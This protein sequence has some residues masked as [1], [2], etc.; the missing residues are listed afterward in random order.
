M[1]KGT[2]KQFMKENGKTIIIGV[3]GGLLFTGGLLLGKQ[4]TLSNIKSDK[5]VNQLGQILKHGNTFKDGIK[6]GYSA[7]Y[8]NNELTVNDLGNVGKMMIDHMQ[9]S[10]FTEVKADSELIGVMVYTN[11]K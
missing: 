8:D 7:I 9:A 2:V 1:K 11:N 10:G 4:I 5:N 6:T 3:A